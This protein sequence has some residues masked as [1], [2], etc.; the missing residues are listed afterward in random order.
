MSVSLCMIHSYIIRLLLLRDEPHIRILDLHPPTNRYLSSHPSVSF[1]KTDI[2][3]LS[4]VRKGL[5]SPF[6]SS[7]GV[8][9][10]P[11]VIFHTAAI[12]RFWERLSYTYSLSADINVRGTWNIVSVASELATLNSQ[13]QPIQPHTETILVYTSSSDLVLPRPRFLKL[14]KDYEE[15]PWNSVV[16]SD[17]NREWSE[18]EERIFGSSSCYTKSKREGEKVVREAHNSAKDNGNGLRTGSLRPGQ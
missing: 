2:T 16:F 15:Y 3:S 10:L 4:S 17:E 11:S 18:E 8:E 7:Q 1:I 5:L 6:I 9:L 12:I 14:G 13:S